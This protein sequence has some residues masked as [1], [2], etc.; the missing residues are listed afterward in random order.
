MS[1]WTNFVSSSATPTTGADRK[2][3]GGG[4]SMHTHAEEHALARGYGHGTCVALVALY[5]SVPEIVCAVSIPHALTH[6]HAHMRAR[7][8]THTKDSCV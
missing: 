6:S 8:H 7:T 3:G 2:R 4:T 1:T 5:R